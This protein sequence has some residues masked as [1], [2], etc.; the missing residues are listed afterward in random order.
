MTTTTT[1]DEIKSLLGL[2]FE[3]E[4]LLMLAQRRD[5]MTPAE[6]YD[7]LQD[8]CAAL[9]DG[10]SAITGAAPVY[11]DPAP[12]AT[13]ATIEPEPEPAPMAEAGAEID[14][15]IV[16]N[17][18]YEEAADADVAQS[19]PIPEPQP[20]PEPEPQPEIQPQPAPVPEPEPEPAPAPAA[21]KA[22]NPRPITLTLND[23][24]R[25]RRSLFGGSDTQM[26]DTLAILAGIDNADDLNDFITN[27]L[28]WNPE[29]QEVADFMAVLAASR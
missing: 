5:D 16:D 12:V 25:F 1:H 7:M 22:A 3:I 24:F 20:E 18:Q 19:M 26:A 23:K 9:L 27:D 29:D 11:P 2:T 21:A 6:I 4:G 17:A 15:E 13:G 14:S 28:C 10:I 8:K